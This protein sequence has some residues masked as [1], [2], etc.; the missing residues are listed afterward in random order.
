MEVILLFSI[1]FLVKIVLEKEFQ[2]QKKANLTASDNSARIS[3]IG[4]ILAVGIGGTF[5]SILSAPSLLEDP[6]RSDRIVGWFGI[7]CF[8]IVLPALGISFVSAI[9]SLKQGQV[10]P[11]QKTYTSYVAG[12]GFLFPIFL[13]LY[14]FFRLN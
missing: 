9:M 5:I 14:F 13:F 4:L 6:E 12:L 10:C 1:F 11:P 3:G 2:Y 7:L 8:T